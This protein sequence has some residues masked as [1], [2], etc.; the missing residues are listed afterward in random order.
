MDVFFKTA[1]QL[2]SSKQLNLSPMDTDGMKLM[3]ENIPSLVLHINVQILN[4]A[5]IIRAINTY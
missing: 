3:Q 5:K 1:H 2:K 4:L